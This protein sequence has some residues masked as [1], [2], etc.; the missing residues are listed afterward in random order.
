MG[1]T[2]A[3]LYSILFLKQYTPIFR[4]FENIEKEKDNGL[5]NP[6]GTV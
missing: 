4:D 3:V 5:G 6:Q 1:L 2:F